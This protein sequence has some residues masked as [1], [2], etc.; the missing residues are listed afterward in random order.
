M[1]TFCRSGCLV[2]PGAATKVDGN[3]AGFVEEVL[4]VFVRGA[5]PA[6]WFV[7]VESVTTPANRTVEV[8]MHALD[9]TAR[10]LPTELALTDASTK[11]ILCGVA[12]SCGDTVVFTDN[13]GT[14]SHEFAV[15]ITFSNH[16]E[17]CQRCA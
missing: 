13:F 5:N 9:T 8:R 15:A 10:T 14:T 4:V 1:V 6:A 7:N 17:R 12:V 16:Y 11:Q 2:C 3:C